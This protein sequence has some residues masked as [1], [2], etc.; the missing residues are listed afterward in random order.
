MP[1][2]VIQLTHND[3][4]KNQFPRCLFN[5]HFFQIWVKVTWQEYMHRTLNGD[6][7]TTKR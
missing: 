7:S 2:K 4:F 5:N 6:Q 1:P 3:T